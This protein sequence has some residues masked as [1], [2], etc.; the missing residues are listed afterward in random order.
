METND[1]KNMNNVCQNRSK[2]GISL[3][4]LVITIIV[5]LIL[6][7]VIVLSIKY[8]NPTN[9][10]DEAIF[11][12]DFV[13]LQ[14]ELTSSKLNEKI[15][16]FAAK[17]D[18][19]ISMNDDKIYDWL[20]SLKDSPL[21]GYVEICNGEVVFIIPDAD[22]DEHKWAE[23]I[24]GAEKVCDTSCAEAPKVFSPEIAANVKSGEMSTQAVNLTISGGVSDDTIEHYYE[25]S[26]D[27]G[28]TFE[29]VTDLGGTSLSFD[30][31][32]LRQIVQ[33]RTVAIVDSKEQRSKVSEFEVYINK[34]GTLAPIITATN[35]YISGTWTG[36]DVT[37]IITSANPNLDETIQYTIAKDSDKFGDWINYEND[38][39]NLT[40][41]ADGEYRVKARTVINNDKIGVESSE[42]L[43]KINKTLPEAPTITATVNGGAIN[44]NQWTN[45]K[46]VDLQLSSV[47]RVSYYEYSLDNGET[48]TRTS[49]GKLSVSEL[50]TTSVIA[51][52]YNMVD[53][54]GATSNAFVV[55]IDQELPVATLSV[56][57]TINSI[58]ANVSASDGNGSGIDT[59][60]FYK[61]DEVVATS[62]TSEY[63][64]Q[65]LTQNT[66]YKIGVVA[67]DVAGNSSKLV[68]KTITTLSIPSPTIVLNNKNWTNSNVTAT[69]SSN[70]TATLKIQYQVVA[71]NAKIVE[72]DWQDYS[73]PITISQNSD[74]YARSLD[75]T[76]QKSEVSKVTVNNIDKKAPDANA[77]SVVATTR[78]I[79]VT[80]NQEDAPQTSE[81]GSSGIN[82]D[83]TQ[84]AIKKG[85]VWSEYQYSNEFDNLTYDTEYYIRTRAYDNAGNYSVSDET[86]IKTQKLEIGQIKF[87]L[88]SS[89][90]EEYVPGTL[91]NKNVIVSLDN[92]S[93]S[94]TTFRSKGGSAQYVSKTSEDTV[95]QT[96]GITT[97]V[98]ETTDG[99]NTVTQEYQIMID[100]TAPSVTSIEVISPDSGKYKMGTKITFKTTW[101]ENLKVIQAPVMKIK[102]GDSSERQADYVSSNDNEIIYEYVIKKDDNGTLI[103]SD[104]L[105]GQVADSVNNVGQ[106]TK[107]D[108]TG[109]SIIAANE[110]SVTIVSSPMNAG[111]VSGVTSAIYLD[112]VTVSAKAKPGYAFKKWTLSNK[113]VTLQ[114]EL[115]PT[116]S[117]KM[118][119]EDVTLTANFGYIEYKIKYDANTG[120][121]QAF[122]STHKYDNKQAL[123]KN[124]YTKDGYTF[125]GW[126]RDKNATEPEF[127]DEEEVLNLTNVDGEVI[128]LYA[129]WKVG[130]SEYKVEHYIENSNS[131]AYILKEVEN[132]TATTDEVATAKTKSYYGFH[133]DDTLTTNV[134]SGT[135]TGDG[136]LVLKLY[137]SRNK[138]TLSIDPNGG[139][140][141]GSTDITKVVGKYE[142]SLVLATPT[143][144]GYVFNGWTVSGKGNINGNKFVFDASDATITATWKPGI[145]EYT[146]E[147]YKENINS[148]G[149][150][151]AEKATMSATT[152]SNVTA[153]IK[154][155][156]GFS[157]NDF[158]DGTVLSGTVMPD[159]SLVLK[160]YYVRNTYNL[161]I[162]PNGGEYRG[163]S[164]SVVVPGKYETIEKVEDAAPTK[165]YKITYNG[166]GGTAAVAED[167]TKN[168][169]SGWLKEGIGEYSSENGEFKYLAGDGL[170]RATYKNDGITLTTATRQGYDLAGWYKDL[171]KVGNARDKY[172]PTTEENLT[173]RW[174]PREDTKYKVEHY[175]ENINKDGYELFE[176]EELEGITDTKATAINKTYEG[177][178]FDNTIEGTVLSGNINPDGSLVL[179]V[180]YTRNT[181]TLSFLISPVNSGSV[182]KAGSYAYGSNVEINAVPAKGYTF[183]NWKVTTN[184][185]TLSNTLTTKTNFTMPD[186]D[187]SITAYFSG[188]NYTIKYDANTG[189]GTMSNSIHTYD[190]AKKLNKNT[191]TKTGYSF[192]G[193]NTDKNATSTAY[194]DEQEVLN[195][196]S[197]NGKI[198][199]LYAIWSA[200]VAQY[201]SEYYFEQL[202]GTYKLEYSE[203]KNET[204]D[205][206]VTVD[207]LDPKGFEYDPSNS[208]SILSGVV[209]NDGSLVLRSYYKRKSYTLSIDPNTGVYDSNSNIT[210]VNGKY[211]Q[212]ITLKVPIKTGYTFNGWQTESKGTISGN[213]YTFSDSDE[214]IKATYVANQYVVTYDY[215]Q[216]NGGNTE[217]TKNVTYD[218]E[219]GALPEPTRNYTVTYDLNNGNVSLKDENTK[220]TYS[221][222]GWYTS[223][224]YTSLI[225][226]TSK[227]NIASNHNLYAKWTGGNVKLP[228]PTRVGYTF[229]GWY[230][231][232]SNNNGSGTKAGDANA[233]YTPTTDITLYAGWI[234]NK[235]TAYKVEHY[236]ENV[237][238]TGFTLTDTDNLTGT[239]GA[240]IT[241][242]PKTYNGYTL[243]RNNSNS[244][245]T[246]TIAADG[247]LVLKLYY[248]RNSYALTVNP[249]GG[250]FRNTNN[251]TTI[252]KKHGQTEN[253]EDPSVPSSH[254]VG[255]EL[256]GG[257]ANLVEQNTT[258][259]YTF[260]GWKLSGVG[261]FDTTSK[262]FTYGIGT[263]TLTA[264]YSLSSIVLPSAQKVGYTFGGWYLD[265]AFKTKAGDQGDTYDI[266]SSITLYAK[267]NEKTDIK[268]QVYHYLENVDATG[269]DLQTA[270]IE[271]GYGRVNSNVTATPKT[272]TGFTY[273][274]AV[275]G[276]ISSANI[277]PDGSLILKLYYTRN[278]YSLTVNPNGGTWNG[279]QASSVI[280]KKH[281]Q[282]LLVGDPV[283]PKAY[284][285]SYELN[286]GSAN[287]AEQNTTANRTFSGWTKSGAGTYNTASKTFTYGIGTASL[288]AN[289]TTSSV[290]LPEVTKVGYNFAGWYKDSNYTTKIGD[291]KANYTPTADTK[292]YA[293]Y[294]ADT[295]TAYVVEHYVQNVS[296]TGYDLKETQTLSGTT[297]ATVTATAKTYTGFTYDSSNAN[298]IASGNVKPGGS[299][300]LKLYYSRND[301]NLTVNPN[302]GTFRNKTTSTVI[303][304]KYQG[305]ETIENPTVPNPYTVTYN[306]NSGTVQ[307]T[308]ENTLAKKAFTS[309]TKSGAGTLS[310]SKVFTFDAGNATLTANYSNGSVK[311]PSATRAGYTFNG[312]Y[313][314]SD[315]L[316]GIAGASYTPTSNITLTAKW[317]ANN[318]AYKV[319]HYL[320]NL[321]GTTY[322]LT[323]TQSLSGPTDSTVNAASKTYTGFTYDSSNKSNVTSGVVK[324]DGSLVLKLYYTR[325]SYTV[326]LSTNPAGAG[327]VTGSGTYKYGQTVSIN[328]TVNNGYTFN[329]WTT[330]NSISITDTKAESTT[331]VMPASNVSV[332]AKYN[333]IGYK[334]NYILNGGTQSVSNPTSYLV[335][336]NDITLNN[337]T[338]DGY[339]FKGWSTPS[340][341]NPYTTVVIKKGS[342]GDRTYIANW[343]YATVDAVDIGSQY[344]TFNSQAGSI[345]SSGDGTFTIYV[346]EADYVFS[347]Q[348]SSGN[349]INVYTSDSLNGTYNKVSSTTSSGVYTT[350]GACYVKIEGK[351][352]QTNVKLKTG[353]NAYIADKLPNYT[354]T[355]YLNDGTNTVHNA[356]TYRK[357]T[358]G[359]Y[360]AAPTRAGYVFKGWDT[361]SSATSGN[362]AET[363]YG[364]VTGN[365]SIYATW[366]KST[367]YRVEYYLENISKTGYELYDAQVINSV[368][369]TTVTA[370][371][372]DYTSIGFD[373]NAQASGTVTSGTVLEDG[374]LT[375]KLY[376]TRRS[377]N[378][379]INPNGGTYSGSASN[380][381]I[382]KPLGAVIDIPVP[383]RS[384]Y[385]FTGW[386]KSGVGTIT[387]TTPIASTTQ[388][389]TYGLGNTSITANWKAVQASYKVE[390][391]KQNLDYTF[392]LAETENKSAVTGTTVT[393]TSKTY[394][395]FDYASSYNGTIT[396]G[397]VKGDGSLVLKLYYTRK[398]VSLTID[399]NGGTYD[400]D[401][402]AATKGGIY[403][404]TFKVDGK[405]VAPAGYKVTYNANGGTSTKSSEVSTKSFNGWTKSGLGSY[406]AVSQTFT[407][408][409]GNAKLTASYSNNSVTL[410]QV[411]FTGYTLE[412]WY[413]DSEFKNRVGSAGAAYTPTAD[414]TLYAKKAS[415]AD[416]KYTVEHYLENADGTYSSTASYKDTL[417]GTTDSTVTATAN[418]YTGYTYDSTIT[419]TVAS[420]K[421]V[422]NGSLVLK[423]YYKRNYYTLTLTS[424]P[425]AGGTLEKSGSY[426]YGTT[427]T[428]KATA[429]PGYTFNGWS[430]ATTGIT[431]ASTSSA[432]TTFVMPAKN[433]SITGNFKTNAYTLTVNPGGTNY[434]QNYLTTKSVTAPKSY[435]TIKYDSNGGTAF[436]NTSSE[437]G[438]SS[439]TLSG[440]GSISSTTANPT[441]YT[442][443]AGNGTLTA[444]YNSK[445]TSYTLPTPSKLGY[446]FN[447]WYDSE[448]N[449]NGSGNLVG[450]A[451]ATYTPTENKTLYAKWTV[452][453]YALTINPG[454][455]TRTGAYAST[456]S[457]TAPNV[458]YTVTY[459]VNGGNSINPQNSQRAFSS[460]SLSGA[461]S[462]SSTTTNPTTFTY[463][464]GSSTLTASYSANGTAYT[465]PTATRAGYT[466]DGWYSTETNN[467][468]SGT[469]IGKAGASYTPSS[470]VTLYAKWTINSYKL[471]VKNGNTVLATY[472]GNYNDTKSVSLSP[473]YTINFNTNGGAAVSSM[474]SN[475][476]VTSWSLSGAGSL[477]STTSNPTIFTFGAGDATLTAT[478]STT[479]SAITLPSTSKTGHTFN[480]WCTDSALT[481]KAGTSGT[482]N[483][484]YTPSGASEAITLY[485]K[486]T[487][488]NYTV[489][490]SSNPS[491]GGTTSGGGSYNYGTSVTV[492][493]VPNTGYSFEGWY[494]GSTKVSSSANYT[495]TL[496]ASNV[497]LVAKFTAGG[498]NYTVNHYV[499]NTSGAYPTTP[500]STETKTA[501]TDSSVTLSNLQKTDSTYKV[502]N[503]IA[504]SYGQVGGTTVTTTT[505]PGNNSRVINLYY[506]RYY[507]TL[508]TKAGTNVSSVTAQS[509]VKYYYG[510]SVPSLTANL[511]TATGYN[512]TFASWASSNTTYMANKT[513]NPT[514]AFAWPAMP[515]GTA[516]TLTANANKT[517]NVY[518][519]SLSN[520]NATTGPSPATVYEKYATGLYSNSACSTAISSI[521]V[522][523]RTGY[524]FGGYYT[525]ANG[526]GTQ[527][528]AADGK[529]TS[530][531]TNTAFTANTTLQPKWTANSVSYKVEHYLMGTN[532]S[533]PTSATNVQT[534]SATADSTVTLANL[535]YTTSAYKV[536]NG[537]AYSYGQ[538]GGTTV[539]TTTIA[540]NGSTVIKL[541]YERYY[542]TLTTKAGTNVSSVTTQN[543]VKY[544]YG[545]TVP[546]LSATLPANPA[547]YHYTFSNWISSNTTYLAN[548]T[549]NPTGTFTWTAMPKGTAITLT[550]N[551]TLDANSGTAYK[552]EHYVMNTSGTYPTTPT[553][554]DS[555]SGTTGATIT[556]SNL[557]NS[558][559]EVA[560]GIVYSYGQVGGTTVTTTTIASDGSTVVKL[561][562]KRTYGTLTTA[563]GNYVS[564]VTPAQSKTKYYYGATVPKLTANL[565][566]SA[567]Y[568]VKFASWT[569]SNSSIKLSS[570]P[571]GTFTWPAM[572]EGTA[573]TIT[574]N[575]TRTANSYTLT[576]NPGGTTAT[577][578]YGTTKS[579]SAPEIDVICDWNY[580][581]SDGTSL[582][583]L[584]PV[585]FK[586]WSLSGSGSVSSATTNP[587]TYTYGAGN[588]TLTANYNSVTL[589]TPTREGYTF[590]GWYDGSTKVGN[591]GSTYTP[592]KRVTLTASW[593]ID[594]YT[595]TV[596]P[597]G[598]T[599]DQNYGTTKSVSAPEIDVICDWNYPGSDGDSLKAL[600]LVE[601]KSWSLNGAGSISSATA[602]PTTYTYGAGNATLTA[603]YNQ[604][605]LP[606]PTREGYTFNGWYDGSTKVGNAGATYT[607]TKKVTLTASWTANKYTLT[608]N[609]GGT[610]ADQ[611]YGTTKSVSAPAV[612]V[613][614]NYES[615]QAS[616]SITATFKSWSLSGSGSIS[617]TTTNPTTYT[618]GAG[619]G[620]LTASYNAIKLPTPNS[621]AGHTFN[622][623][624]DGS[625][626]VGGAGDSYTP[627]KSVTLKPSWT[628]NSYTLT[629]NPGGTTTTQKW[630][631]TKSVSAPT[632]QVTFDLNYDSKTIVQTATFKSWSLSGSGSISSTTANPTTYTYGAGN[633]TLTANYNSVITGP[634][635][636]VVREGY[637]FAG[638]YTAATGGTKISDD[639]FGYGT[640]GY[641]PTNSI[642]L[643]AHWTIN[644]YTLTVNPGGEKT[645]QNYGTTKS[646][647]APA[648]ILS[649][650]SNGGTPIHYQQIGLK[651]WKLSGAG[652]ISST[653]SDPTTYTYG[654]GDATLTADYG[655]ITLAGAPI[656]GGYTFTGWYNDSTRVG[657]EGDSYTITSSTSLTAHWTP[658]VYTITLN[659]QSATSA[660]S[661]A[662]YE[663]YETGIYKE[664]GCTTAMAT[665][666]NP[667]T[668]PKKSGYVFAGYYTGTNGSGTQMINPKGYI[669][670]DFTNTT[671][672]SNTTLYAY[673][674][675]KNIYLRGLYNNYYYSVSPSQG[676]ISVGGNRVWFYIPGPGYILDFTV[677]SGSSLYKMGSNDVDA[678]TVALLDTS[679][680]ITTPAAGY[681]QISGASSNVVIKTADGNVCNIID[682]LQISLVGFYGNMTTS[683][684]S[685]DTGSKGTAEFTLDGGVAAA[686]FV[687]PDLTNL[688]GG[689]VFS[690]S[691][692]GC[693]VTHSHSLNGTYSSGGSVSSNGT[694]SSVSSYTYYK[695]QGSSMKIEAK[696]AN[697]SALKIKNNLP[698][699]YIYSKPTSITCKGNQIYTGT[700]SII[701]KPENSTCTISSS[702]HSSHTFARSSTQ[703]GTY[704]TVATWANN[705][706]NVGTGSYSSITPA[707]FWKLTGSGGT[708]YIKD[709]NGSAVQFVEK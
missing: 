411:T 629:V 54:V 574:A 83:R 111:E 349:T 633:G 435:Y 15:N 239:T 457:V 125:A 404:S 283:T 697:G 683:H 438:F 642:T 605:T 274:S 162:D 440:A 249:N 473:K 632:V 613:S 119:A 258:A 709:S 189:A 490:T 221:F 296:G 614:F 700:G 660:G 535:A 329:S 169:F 426:K 132:L 676:K 135:V 595:L 216:A 116:T 312:W 675:S 361:N 338:R 441:T 85:D 369:G 300:V 538:V 55:K 695:F 314:S 373:Y 160:V 74:V 254:K 634:V 602:N 157:K 122:E 653:T 398:Q 282:S 112:D 188:I 477:S 62:K 534:L 458:Y 663:K 6:L 127:L 95:I 260:N 686:I 523:T 199:T 449:N 459:D 176:T 294:I 637:T 471:T 679:G 375:L 644:S 94:N 191:F 281:G 412:G 352:W 183:S 295:D 442:Y 485:A 328:A 693:S 541:Y 79:T 673:W 568:T 365:V 370:T 515:E 423:L 98:A 583:A 56:S 598:T 150:D 386:T 636:K 522:P 387:T 413:S 174:T 305:T 242:T 385:E 326:S 247:S 566:S 218:S 210:T 243:D 178:T 148:T 430:T 323:E 124:T 233:S 264:E 256:N 484:S 261:N 524:T 520:S 207:I 343:Q 706:A 172:V 231:A 367:T 655:S 106:G 359:K 5:S 141:S 289:Y 121:G 578:N 67:I 657:G 551:A 186:S 506:K 354:I 310:S 405:I 27:K 306:A 573:V 527:M 223:K 292:L 217:K 492:K 456:T 28:E 311:L 437:R 393:A 88:E 502:T 40:F 138:Y 544:Y 53:I 3:I 355:A 340:D 38:N 658:N 689:V 513:A 641:T 606:T 263:A 205:S 193:W 434:S 558:G 99:V 34:T 537:I 518:T 594:K 268:Y 593:T 452:N 582:K 48:W 19:N 397:V 392:T 344:V 420:G 170:L 10:A 86:R 607:P 508:T 646:V 612:T 461:G 618:Y 431:I 196:A 483:S 134:T 327:K 620:T 486:F 42:F 560:N 229:G 445:G 108:L 301:Y 494:N 517:A 591:A 491:A 479:G 164:T 674:Q 705:G 109:N 662:V 332:T 691:S 330:T 325:N 443:G 609:P 543:A 309:W 638:W 107:K 529:F 628:V 563:T 12:N 81:Y 368:T 581:G 425:S 389:F 454:G 681:Y 376:Y 699:V 401:T 703:N 307:V 246:S 227:V 230:L 266:T 469:L 495:F 526:S 65:N 418:T 315:T 265:S 625:T 117:F 651:S 14:N 270:D 317:T 489:S 181:H 84:Y 496:G 545:A 447:G 197:E 371:Q 409:T 688:V 87:T 382:N 493:A 173:A 177:F 505:I 147:Y 659:N 171:V 97:I 236:L 77:P 163:V 576:V 302:G 453:S 670:S 579:V 572:A 427:V 248:T 669:T 203:N 587:T 466:F 395:G 225:V 481:T 232:E 603:N 468:G 444:N 394:D 528:I 414:I 604:I 396:S 4:V 429:K 480:Y 46:P 432:T 324:A 51:R 463:G 291:A 276:T 596:N 58:A 696:G 44:S 244:L 346:Q 571:S 416:T 224:D 101:T 240:T 531:F 333:V 103:L 30:G 335:T 36:S 654:A 682:E 388:K 194:L 52:A 308:D 320:Q 690:S 287:L 37:L 39:P 415:N 475:R 284:T 144:Q 313:N 509:A 347:I 72:S 685:A 241:A 601:F 565:T 624:Y 549:T 530:N 550:A 139:T 7:S 701:F 153:L 76:N 702:V 608:V 474:T 80:C 214:K 215:M 536:T 617:S 251:K 319:E 151:L 297:G 185:T 57:A 17:E 118:P 47:S 345:S 61:N 290:V 182:T 245:I 69:I 50:G 285:V 465:L 158:V 476:T 631:T 146:I 455:E 597:G 619:N 467:N 114:N 277:L 179:K 374:S 667:I 488:N 586:S 43:V 126:S 665:T 321:D 704:T 381:V 316:I 202:D 687:Y 707:Y 219:Y 460:W 627:T 32:F 668:I 501:T 237:T 666:A 222:A 280:N 11:R 652:S 525:G 331:F 35:D 539:T 671:F 286:G 533:Y 462:L 680:T 664:S 439:W 661:T 645:T 567:G 100:K 75:N 155:Y 23:K 71:K 212:T 73:L 446:T 259:K 22:T 708:S 562:Y 569:S 180:Y 137:Y 547:G 592:T 555:K 267:W 647:S 113:S 584:I 577:Q 600:F 64:F 82:K 21:K 419:G 257:S 362:A 588:G 635:G 336:S 255:Y 408:G 450:N 510:A 684:I 610:T 168:V 487:V 672:T 279:T 209:S 20:P 575:A 211:E 353:E 497:S 626:K 564:S 262:K 273:N 92:D 198:V 351:D 110:F 96:E 133:Y 383:V 253:I 1:A 540:A 208:N 677:N 235:S 341:P 167:Y 406:D 561:Y 60:V 269:Y 559:H 554:T 143:K 272:Y 140:Y 377:Y 623:W 500:T 293:Y 694:A 692:S 363:D 165:G 622:G 220:S 650:N 298:N 348:S 250:T 472:N 26:L 428:I 322:T 621:W 698:T 640:T 499:M 66:S 104:Y 238:A 643:Y 448:T 649:Y 391:Y 656:R 25:Y 175:R 478:Y 59:Y 436:S 136:K 570:N 512:V 201:K 590:N 90:N 70:D 161:T 24:A 226:A 410:P 378:L 337:P 403:G 364:Y 29:N 166:N 339:A 350:T 288:V 678:T 358:M 318:V 470:N 548:K 63:T 184:N 192:I 511:A 129:V 585:T 89:N 2:K 45:K 130:I 516:I 31:A 400:G 304:K 451:G 399:P 204:V 187:V 615:G 357:Y 366:A 68:E 195:L 521:T 275:S 580:P 503:G 228:E 390:H 33:V 102:F 372:R 464:A 271:T 504:Y 190:V 334:I 424:S 252:T 278:L 123:A 556:L 433:V 152:E 299:L 128:T 599:T 384:G 91:T 380:T 145:S 630:N 156:E 507:G 356:S 379:T 417:Y 519:I 342:I 589:P 131:S 206:T 78:K 639:K 552:V 532:G 422:A 105:E 154:E 234:S 482:A 41:T 616:S 553:S 16:D 115:S 402:S 542:G 93:K 9:K 421:V 18:I 213:K 546:T 142:A 303:T 120:K 49:N 159:N 13:V 611:N 407:Y 514:G 149:Y 200:G 498:S 8:S 648:C 360:P 557:K